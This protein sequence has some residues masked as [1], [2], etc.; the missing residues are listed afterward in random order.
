LKK[1]QKTAIE[2]EVIVGEETEGRVENEPSLATQADPSSVTDVAPTGT[3]TISEVGETVTCASFIFDGN[4]L[5]VMLAG[6][7]VAPLD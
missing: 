7:I 6:S 5:L 4:I 3:E 1:V 2:P